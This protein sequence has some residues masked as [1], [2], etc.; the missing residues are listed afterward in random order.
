MLT[1][2]DDLFIKISELLEQNEKII[3]TMASVAMNRLKYVFRYYEKI[4]IDRIINLSYFDNFEC[5]K[6]TPKNHI[7]IPKHAKYVYLKTCCSD[8]PEFVTHL[9]FGTLSIGQIN[10]GANRSIVN[11]PMS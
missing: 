6:L 2:Y 4:N 11:I 5:V 10:S 7:R 1:L 3:L 9:V 8:I